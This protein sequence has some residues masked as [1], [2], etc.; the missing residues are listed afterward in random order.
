MSYV[1]TGLTR[2]DP[3]CVF[4]NVK[5][6][7]MGNYNIDLLNPKTYKRKIMKRVSPE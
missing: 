5:L 4:G 2:D 3:T 6:E 7:K 1:A